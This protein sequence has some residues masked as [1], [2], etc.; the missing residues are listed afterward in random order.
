MLR[1][2]IRALDYLPPVDVHFG[3]F[4]R[5]ILTADTDLVPDDLMHYRPAVI[6]AFSPP[7]HPARP[8]PVAGAGQPALGGAHRPAGGGRVARNC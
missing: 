6:Q 3:E 1:L 2:R 7:Q 5:A 4:L 8:M